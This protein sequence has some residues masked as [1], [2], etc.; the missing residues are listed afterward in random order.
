MEQHVLALAKA[1]PAYKYGWRPAPGVRSFGEVFLPIAE[2]NQL[3]LK[4]AAGEKADDQAKPGSEAPPKEQI[5]QK[6]TESFAAVRSALE[7]ARAASLNREVSF[8]GTNTT[9]RGVLATLDT[10]IAEHLGQ[11]I[12]YARMNGIV[13]PWSK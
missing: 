1:I 12:A 13:P 6:L 11:A 9:Q 3:M 5:L 8:F 2:G 10:H 4:L 7:N